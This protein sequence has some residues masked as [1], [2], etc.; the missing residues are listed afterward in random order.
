MRSERTKS[1]REGGRGADAIIPSFLTGPAWGK[2]MSGVSGSRQF[3]RRR[4]H[5][6]WRRVDDKEVC[7]EQTQPPHDI[8][9]AVLRPH[10]VFQIICGD[11]QEEY[12]EPKGEK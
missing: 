5:Q 6:T 4:E 9:T 10:N 11:N 1:E 7:L 12:R 2:L 8:L 3:I